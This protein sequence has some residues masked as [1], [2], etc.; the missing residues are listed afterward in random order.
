MKILLATAIDDITNLINNYAVEYNFQIEEIDNLSDIERYIT[1]FKPDVILLSELFGEGESNPREIVKFIRSKTNARII[2]FCKERIPGDPFLAF[3]V[4]LGIY[5]IAYRGGLKIKEI[6]DMILNPST[7]GDVSHLILTSD[8]FNSD[9]EKTVKEMP[10]EI[11][12]EKIVEKPVEVIKEKIVEK[13][14]EIV[15]EKI[16]EKPVE[17]VKEKVVEKPVEVVKEKIV[18]KPVEIIKEVV[19][20]VPKE[21]I[22]EVIK[23]VKVYE[24]P[25]GFKK[26]ICF[27]SPY[28][29]GKTFLSY[30]IAKYLTKEGN[31]VALADFDLHEHSLFYY[32]DMKDYPYS[33]SIMHTI[34]HPND[35]IS[36]K[37][38]NLS[39]YTCFKDVKKF[40]VMMDELLVF[41]NSVKS[42]NDIVIYDT[43]NNSTLR[44]IL[45]IVDEIYLVTNLEFRVI[46]KLA[47]SIKNLY[48]NIALNKLSL[49]V[50]QYV[51]IKGINLKDVM[52]YL[53]TIDIDG[54]QVSI[55]F[56]NIFTVPACSELVPLCQLNNTPAF[57]LKGGEQLGEAISQISNAIYSIRKEKK[58][59]FSL[60]RR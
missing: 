32:F 55:K 4:N 38:G 18:E 45:S 35:D 46:D 23:E 58:K 40:D 56:N 17:I 2:Y 5:D 11:I 37:E 15:K 7:W 34:Q 43:G 50:N 3:L 39:V 19:K 29:V 57:N 27:Y 44:H 41:N 48:N 33:N 14:V 26:T 21:I 6:I 53:K 9:N 51:D 52:E 8:D 47:E 1:N 24:K 22:K 49:I 36:Y 16:I 54:K 28:S 31:K 10:K 59:G 25:E 42:N 20:E 60:F 30:N 12:K 13:P